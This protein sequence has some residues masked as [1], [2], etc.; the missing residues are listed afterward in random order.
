MY[1]STSAIDLLPTLQHLT[2][3]EISSWAEGAILPP[4]SSSIPIS[5]HD[6]YALHGDT[7]TDGRI[8]KGTAMLVRDNYKL[9][10]YFGYEQLG[11]DREMVELY[12]LRT[13][14]E[15]LNNLH[16]AQSSLASDLLVDLKSR[17]NRAEDVYTDIVS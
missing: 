5:D 1:D 4:F 9:M 12:D 11:G 17:L 8:T 10:W 15:E 14:P 16:P 3:Q 13:D 2:G 7:G 6:V